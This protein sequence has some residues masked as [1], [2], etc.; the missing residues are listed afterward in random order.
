MTASSDRFSL[1]AF[2]RWCLRALVSSLW[3]LS[4]VGSSPWSPTSRWRARFWRFNSRFSVRFSSDNSYTGKNKIAI[5]MIMAT[6]LCWIW[7]HYLLLASPGHIQYLANSLWSQ[8]P[9]PDAYLLDKLSTFFQIWI[10]TWI[11]ISRT[12][13]Q[14]SGSQ[15]I[16]L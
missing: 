2:F 14:I 5:F 1:F 10:S 6:E 8:S 16:T 4:K 15:S 12:Q 11:G 7:N 13:I 3:A 9:V